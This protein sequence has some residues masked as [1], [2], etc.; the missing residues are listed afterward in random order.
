MHNRPLNTQLEEIK[1]KYYKKVQYSAN[2]GKHQGLDDFLPGYEFEQKRVS[3]S[4]NFI[5]E[6]DP[7]V[8]TQKIEAI[9]VCL[10]KNRSKGLRE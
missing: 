8:H 4:K 10:K 3:H 5:N 2:I 9:L 1:R 6:E 7:E